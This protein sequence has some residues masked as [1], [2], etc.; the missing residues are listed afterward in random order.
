MKK[1][2]ISAIAA[3]AFSQN[4]FAANGLTAPVK[5]A[6]LGIIAT[7]FGGHLPG[8]MEV[9]VLGGFALPLGVVCNNV[10]ITTKKTLDSD[11]AMFNL[12]RDAKQAGRFVR[13]GIDNN[14][15]FVAFPGRCSLVSVEVQ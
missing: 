1:L 5:V 10:F 7:A 3:L 4:V 12:L 11:R 14:P 15:A 13:L 2:Y 6:S 8:N 9:R